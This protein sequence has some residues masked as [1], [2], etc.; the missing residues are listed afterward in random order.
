MAVG[1]LNTCDEEKS[2]DVLR[3]VLVGGGFDPDG[4]VRE[5]AGV[6]YLGAARGADLVPRTGHSQAAAVRAAGEKTRRAFW[7]TIGAM[8]IAA[9]DP[10]GS[11]ERSRR[12]CPSPRPMLVAAP[13]R[14]PPGPLAALRTDESSVPRTSRSVRN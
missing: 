10:I 11:P 3:A 14:Q 13:G 5:D 9:I 1:R 4:I 12:C 2:G 6:A 7:F 8:H